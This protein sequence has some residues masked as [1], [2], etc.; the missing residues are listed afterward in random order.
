MHTSLMVFP[1][2]LRSDVADAGLVQ[3]V[4]LAFISVGAIPPKV[5]YLISF[6][7]QPLFTPF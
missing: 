5:L 6:Y 2:L 4:N 1:I 3:P 7:F